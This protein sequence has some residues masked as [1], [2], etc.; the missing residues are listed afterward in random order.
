MNFFKRYLQTIMDKVKPDYFTFEKDYLLLHEILATLRK[1]GMTIT[2]TGSEA[3]GYMPLYEFSIPTARLHFGTLVGLLNHPEKLQP[4]SGVIYYWQN[5]KL[6]R[7]EVEEIKYTWYEVATAIETLNIRKEIKVELQGS[8][9]EFKEK[10]ITLTENGMASLNTKKYLKQ[11]EK[12]RNEK[13]AY[14]STISTNYWMRLFTG[15]LAFTAIVTLIVQFS[16]CNKSTI[17][18]CPPEKESPKLKTYLKDSIYIELDTLKGVYSIDT[19]QKLKT[20][21]KIASPI[22]NLHTSKK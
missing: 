2:A 3:G 8:S 18:I 10:V 20:E 4:E 22:K 11:F 17:L 19:P 5:I 15:I 1:V 7:E 14:R 6:K 12:E 16:T 9:L 13:I 21:L